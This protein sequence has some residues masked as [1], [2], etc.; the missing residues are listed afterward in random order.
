[1]RAPFERLKAEV[2]QRRQLGMVQTSKDLLTSKEKVQIGRFVVDK[3]CRDEEK[4][5]A[6][7]YKSF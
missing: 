1:M 2:E 4:R 5:E 3:I 6:K 7:D